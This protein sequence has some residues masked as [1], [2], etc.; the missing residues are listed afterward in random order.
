MLIDESDVKR[1]WSKV[2]KKSDE[3]CWPWLAGGSGSGMNS[4]RKILIGTK[5]CDTV[6]NVMPCVNGIA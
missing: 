5:A 1:F 2:D 6:E 4:Q 3:E